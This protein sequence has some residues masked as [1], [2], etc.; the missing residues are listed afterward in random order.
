MNGAYVADGRFVRR[1]PTKKETGYTYG[2]RVCELCG[3]LPDDA[4]QE[5]AEALNLHMEKYPEKH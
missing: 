1:E 3:E 5:I 2:F 4:A